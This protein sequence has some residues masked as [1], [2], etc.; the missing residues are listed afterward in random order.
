MDVL[1]QLLV[2]RQHIR[3]LVEKY[4]E[5]RTKM[6]SPPSASDYSDYSYHGQRSSESRIERLHDKAEKL[7]EKIADEEIELID[8]KT[9]VYNQ[10]EQLSDETNKDI[11]FDRYVRGYKWTEVARK[12]DVGLRHVFTMHQKALKEWDQVHGK[13]GD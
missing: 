9:A 6:L 11:L 12:Y 2:K 10:I 4:E 1:N 5:I 3:E 8:L 13:E 7:R